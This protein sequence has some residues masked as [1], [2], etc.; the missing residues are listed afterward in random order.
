MI[1]NFQQTV[2]IYVYLNKHD[3]T[4]Y[5]TYSSNHMYKGSVVDVDTSNAFSPDMNYCLPSLRSFI[6]TYNTFN[7]LNNQL[8]VLFQHINSSTN[9]QNNL[10]IVDF[11]NSCSVP[12]VVL[13]VRV[14]LTIFIYFCISWISWPIKRYI[15]RCI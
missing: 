8:I 6:F 11:L 1:Y 4:L 2:W 10:D 15:N 13:V 14:C 3:D 5:S 12:F 9:S 7:F